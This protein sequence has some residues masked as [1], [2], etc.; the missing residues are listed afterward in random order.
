MSQQRTLQ[1]NFGIPRTF[2]VRVPVSDHESLH[3]YIH[4]LSARHDVPLGHTLSRLGLVTDVRQKPLT[5]FGIVMPDEQ[6]SDFS[7]VAGISESQT[8]SLLLSKFSGVCLNLDGVKLGVND[9]VRKASLSEWAYFSGS[10][11]CPD[12]LRETEG[13]W[14]LSWKLPWSF[15]CVKHQALLHDHCPDCGQRP[16]TGYR[17]GSLSPAFIG[18]VPRPG[19]C[20]NVL[21]P[22]LAS[23]GKGSTP[24]GCN[25][26]ELDSHKGTGL[27]NLLDSQKVIDGYLT[28]RKLIDTGES[29][30]FFRE[31]RSVCALILY[32]AELEDF[33][34]FP[35]F[36]Q[37][38]IALHIAH[39]NGAQEER[40]VGGAGRNGAKPRMFI[41]TPKNALLMA[42]VAFVALR[43]V[44]QTDPSALRE[45]LRVLGER[46]CDRSSKYRYAVLNYFDLSDRLRSALTDAIAARGSFDRRAGHRSNVK[47]RVDGKKSD[48]EG[49]QYE[50]RHVPQCIPQTVFDDKLKEFFPNVQDRFARRF[51]SLAAVKSLGYTWRESALLL[52]LPST[53]N[54]MAN[55]CVMLLK[56]QGDYD[57]FAEALYK[58]T[59]D[60][61]GAKVRLD[62]EKRRAAFRS[63]IDFNDDQWTKICADSGVSKGNSGSRSKYAATW[64]WAEMTVGDW[65]LAPALASHTNGTHQH[66]VYGTFVKTLLPALSAA[67]KR[68]GNQMLAEYRQD[69]KL[70]KS[71]SSSSS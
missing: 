66:D 16:A 14:N 24:C 28:D 62:H 4:R 7:F 30:T 48:A 57:R 9:T 21:P 51:C 56:Q 69:Q 18:K 49:P 29:L 20:T 41:G 54:G 17:D 60:I 3:S 42:A 55:R 67:L 64:L 23:R 38:A 2:P 52:E 37:E 43:I 34:R 61:A 6:V 50:S 39:R 70:N 25:L 58:W 11:F 44:Q 45:S 27:K 22:G 40:S 10:H 71:S 8:R 1:P 13:A 26:M 59:K 47:T 63:F 33:P 65:A 31:M 46:T 19:F 35:D 36:V 32:R 53:M 68:E 15:A 5:G 12:C